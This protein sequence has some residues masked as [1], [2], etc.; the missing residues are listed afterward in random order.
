LVIGGIVAGASLSVLTSPGVAVA[1][2]A[3]FLVSELADMAVYTP[4]H[5]NRPYLAVMLSNT[6][7]AV[8]DSWIFLYLAFGSIAYWRGQVVGK[9]WTILP[10]L[11]FLWLWRHRDLSERLRPRAITA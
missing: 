7:G 10:V 11:V 9:L 3:A 2:G 8:I 4:L 6:V 5:R 1:S